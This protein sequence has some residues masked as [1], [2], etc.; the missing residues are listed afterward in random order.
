MDVVT[1][2]KVE[3]QPAAEEERGGYKAWLGVAEDAS[4]D[5]LL[6]V[7]VDEVA[8]DKSATEEVDVD[9]SIE[10]GTERKTA[11]SSLSRFLGLGL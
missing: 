11:E 7:S 9:D 3:I 6:G 5:E 10:V 2:E 1:A 4:N 8:A